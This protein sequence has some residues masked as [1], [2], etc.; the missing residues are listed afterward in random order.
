MSIIVIMFLMDCPGVHYSDN[1]LEGL[2]KCPIIV[3]MFLKDCPRVHDSDNSDSVGVGCN[4]VV[5][6]R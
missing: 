2:S 6:R 1:V 5:G 4:V 3:I